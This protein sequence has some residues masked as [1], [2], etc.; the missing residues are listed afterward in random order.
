VIDWKARSES[1]QQELVNLVHAVS[2]DLRAP[3][4]A[5]D[6]FS[7]ALLTRHAASLDPQALDYLQRIRAAA[8]LMGSHIDALTRL[9]RVAT[10]ELRQQKVDLA[11][12]ARIT[13]DDLRE[14]APERQV[15]VQIEERLEVEGDPALLRTLVQNLLSNAWKFT[16]ARSGARIEFQRRQTEAEVVYLV[17]DNGV[18][19]D[20]AY[21]SHLFEPF[22]RLHPADHYEGVGIGLAI[23]RRIVHRHGGRLWA[24]AAPDAGATFSFTLGELERE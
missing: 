17:R 18:G 2:H 14:E 1:L 5:A 24:E 22:G 23:S 12:I 20:M 21:A 4:R 7:R 6:G 8:A 13:M 10:A 11:A 16:R 9:A 3:L 15:A 19:F